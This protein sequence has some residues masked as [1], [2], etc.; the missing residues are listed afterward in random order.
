MAELPKEAADYIHYL[1]E[2]V[3]CPIRYISVGPERE[4]YFI[5]E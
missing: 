3:G 4:Q 2:Q 1:Q 5:A